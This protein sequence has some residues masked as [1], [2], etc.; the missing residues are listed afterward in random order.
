MT[1]HRKVFSHR[2][3]LVAYHVIKDKNRNWTRLTL[4]NN[5]AVVGEHKVADFVDRCK[6]IFEI[7]I[8]WLLQ[9][10]RMDV[11]VLE[12]YAVRALEQVYEDVSFTAF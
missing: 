10:F 2:I 11:H 7:S 8:L 3:L 1:T 12:T 9:Q 6:Q 5:V 4:W